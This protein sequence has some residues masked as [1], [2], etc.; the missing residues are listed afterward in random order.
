MSNN[1]IAAG[2]MPEI[3]LACP[4]LS[5]RIRASFSR[6]SFDKPPTAP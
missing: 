6:T 4:M 2:V 1:E 5:G 3:R